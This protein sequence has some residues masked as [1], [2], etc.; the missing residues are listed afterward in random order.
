M[1]TMLRRMA[2]SAYADGVDTPRGGWEAATARC[3][4]AR[5]GRLPNPRRVSLVFHPHTSNEDKHVRSN[6]LPSKSGFGASAKI[7]EKSDIKNR[8]LNF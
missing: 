6:I 8:N 5:P 3:R 7:I 2:P 1:S 4:V